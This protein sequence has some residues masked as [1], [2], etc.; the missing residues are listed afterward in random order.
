MPIPELNKKYR[1]T[2]SVTHPNMGRVLRKD[3]LYICKEIN[4]NTELI[5]MSGRYGDGVICS[6][7]FFND[8][9]EEAVAARQ[10][11]RLTLTAAEANWLK[12]FFKKHINEIADLD[13]GTDYASLMT[14]S[15][16]IENM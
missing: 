16:K 8:H 3:K 14:V 12:N 5:S 1:C 6:P 7:Q 4:S 2:H 13:G 11:K 9:F 15:D 10:S